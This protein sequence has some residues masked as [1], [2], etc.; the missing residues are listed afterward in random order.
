MIQNQKARL[1]G[2]VQ[3]EAEGFREPVG[4]ASHT[5]EHHTTDDNVVEVCNQEQAVVQ[6]EVCAGTAS[7][8][9][10]IPPTE[11]V[12][13]KP[14]VHSIAELNSIRPDTW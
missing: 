1:P 14:M 6:H 12:T 9:P 10:V 8:T 11:K 3:G 13:R 2:F 4:H 7:S 5:T